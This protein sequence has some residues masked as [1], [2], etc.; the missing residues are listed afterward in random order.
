M[1]KLLCACNGKLCDGICKEKNLYR[2]RK[3]LDRCPAAFEKQ[4]ERRRTNR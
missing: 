1:S 4:K 3:D 2:K